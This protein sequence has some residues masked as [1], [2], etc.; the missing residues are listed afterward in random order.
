MK[1][2]TYLLLATC[3]TANFAHAEIE[4]S[5]GED[6]LAE[7][8]QKLT[9]I[10]HHLKDQRVFIAP[11]SFEWKELK[12]FQEELMFT[13]AHDPNGPGSK[14]G[15][16]ELAP[17]FLTQ[18]LKVAFANL[19]ASVF[20]IGHL[21][22]S[23]E[24]IS[25]KTN[26]EKFLTYRED[27]LYAPARALMKSG[28]V[29][30]EFDNLNNAAKII[31]KGNE[32]SKNLSVRVIDPVIENLS[33]E[34]SRLNTSVGQLEELRKPQPIIPKTI[35]LEKNIQELGFLAITAMAL[36]FLATMFF[37]WVYRSFSKTEAVAEAPVAP[38]VKNGFNYHDW[39]KHLE[40]NL[41]AF[42]NSEDKLVEECIHLKHLGTVLSDARRGLNLA[43]NNQEYY[44]SLEKLNSSAP[45]LEDY[46]E[47][48]NIKKNA[49][50]SRRLIKQVVQLCDAI[51]A[52]QEI[53]LT[54][55]KEKA[56]SS[57]SE[58]QVTELNV[59]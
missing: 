34:L 10:N 59:A 36:G 13:V 3:C 16:R 44:E 48:I 12:I 47:K 35:F 9:Q 17:A 1:C 52:K 33:Q 43:D 19:E 5:G 4:K 45:K 55:S 22:K 39:L 25:V 53:I 58:A 41:K 57:K 29:R 8:S 42:K 6:V 18:K 37:Q 2:F 32:T 7:V 24:W 26:M 15:P 27:F 14:E 31:L 20:Q 51:E 21:R 54:E 38:V 49:E 40:V 50:M 28:D 46:F 23:S 11:A 30:A 56:K